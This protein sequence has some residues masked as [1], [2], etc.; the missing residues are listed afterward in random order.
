MP[1][2]LSVQPIS[3][4]PPVFKMKKNSYKVFINDN[5]SSAAEIAALKKLEKKHEN[6]IINYR[7]S[8]AGSRAHAE[9]LDILISMADTPYAVVLDSDCTFLRKHWDKLMLSCIDEKTKIVGA[10]TPVQRAGKRIGGGSFPLSFAVLFETHIYKELDISCLPGDITKG[11][12]TCWQWEHKFINAGYRGHSFIAHNTR[13][14]KNGLFKDFVGVEEYYYNEDTLLAAHFG[15]GSSLGGAK[16][17][18]WLRIPFISKLVK[19]HI[20]KWDKRRWI[21]RCYDIINQQIKA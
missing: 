5:G 14:Y 13:D 8:H 11:E 7:I 4:F 12:D 3:S 9:A 18:K 15:R 10:A 20:G 6:I 2:R 16:Y 19:Q 1:T 17:L 21:A